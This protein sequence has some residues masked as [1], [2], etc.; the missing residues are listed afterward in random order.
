MA[1]AGTPA[2]IIARLNQAMNEVLAQ[3]DF[4]MRLIDMG[5]NLIGGSP[6]QFAATLARETATW[7]KVINEA[8]ISAPS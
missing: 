1:P 4:R 5:F 6:E 2:P 8:K 7:R 3:P